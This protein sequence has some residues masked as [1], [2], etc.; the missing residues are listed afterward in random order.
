[1]ILID[2]SVAVKWFREE[3]DSD[4]AALFYAT[5]AGTMAAPDLFAIEVA[6][7]LVRNANMVKDARPVMER[8]LLAFDTLLV[9]G[10]VRLIS[11][12]PARIQNASKLA[13]DL[14]HPLKDCLYLALAMEQKC[15][16]VT[17]DAQ[18]AA[19]AQSVWAG[20]RGLEL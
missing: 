15:D 1:M 7:A 3:Q 19:K 16:L 20:V 13:L 18:F 2:A 5:H 9:G 11:T 14:G 12:T 8:A 4:L 6:A 10:S 17:C